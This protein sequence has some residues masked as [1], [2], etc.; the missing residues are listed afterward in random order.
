MHFII[1]YW[2]DLSAFI[3]SLVLNCVLSWRYC[4]LKKINQSQEREIEEVHNQ[5]DTEINE[6][7]RKYYRLIGTAD[8]LRARLAKY[9]STNKIEVK[10]DE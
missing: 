2:V 3:L 4:R 7:K 1:P 10:F 8:G 6:L 9:K 5:F